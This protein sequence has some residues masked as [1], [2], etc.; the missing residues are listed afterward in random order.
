MSVG[1]GSN[2]HE[3]YFIGFSES[4][5]GYLISILHANQLK[6]REYKFVFKI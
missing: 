5:K 4:V 1:D 6:V 3:K 2:R